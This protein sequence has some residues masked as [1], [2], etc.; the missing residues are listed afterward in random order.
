MSIEHVIENK[1]HM[2]FGS[3]VVVVAITIAVTI[4]SVAISTMAITVAIAIVVAIVITIVVA[5]T[6]TIVVAIAIIIAAIGVIAT[7]SSECHANG[8]D[9]EGSDEESLGEHLGGWFSDEGVRL[10]D[11][12]A[13]EAELWLPLLWR[14]YILWSSGAR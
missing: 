5:I 8:N 10:G 11:W 2:L 14:P 12:L 6:F 13:V 9:E 4:S 3:V 7:W 1:S